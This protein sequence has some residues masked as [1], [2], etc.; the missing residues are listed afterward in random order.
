MKLDAIDRAILSEL[1]RNARV[2]NTVLAGRVG[3]SAPACLQ[4]GPRPLRRPGP[5]ASCKNSNG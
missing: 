3:L 2:K 4:R 1:Q 5:S